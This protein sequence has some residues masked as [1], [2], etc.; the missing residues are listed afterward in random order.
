[1]WRNM[2]KMDGFSLHNG[3]DMHE[4]DI[5]CTARLTIDEKGGNA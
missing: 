5:K 4:T 2:A 3:F 1:M